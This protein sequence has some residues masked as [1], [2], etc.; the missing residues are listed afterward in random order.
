PGAPVELYAVCEPTGN[1]LRVQAWVKG[2]LVA[3]TTDGPPP[4]NGWTAG[5]VQ[6]RE[7]RQ[8]GQPATEVSFDDFAAYQ[9]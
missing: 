1:G 8:V 9:R 4:A 3:E 2:T 5:L 7:G 6:G